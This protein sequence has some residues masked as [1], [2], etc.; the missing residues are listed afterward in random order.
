MGLQRKVRSRIAAAIILTASA[1]TLAAQQPIIDP[2]NPNGNP[3]RTAAA[4]AITPTLLDMG[5]GSDQG[6][7][8]PFVTLADKQFARMTAERAMVD[9]ELSKAALDKTESD[10]VR[11][12]GQQILDDYAKWTPILQKVSSRVEIS[13]PTELDKK[14][15]A[16]VDRIT[17][18]TGAEF[19]Q[20]CLK[21]MVRLQNKALT[22]TQYEASHAGVTAFRNWAGIIIPS[23]QDQLRMAKQGLNGEQL[24]GRK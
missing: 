8:G 3:Q 6:N 23:I 20:A 12:L 14:H 4:P 24:A 15:R 7:I 9:V 11:R 13:L 10:K 1:T 18:L 19:D 22:I 21:E 16:D 2:T 17:A 5:T